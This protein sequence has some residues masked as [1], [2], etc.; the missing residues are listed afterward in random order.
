[1][2]PFPS[3]RCLAV[4][5][6]ALALIAPNALQANAAD[7]DLSGSQDKPVVFGRS[8]DIEGTPLRLEQAHVS[9]SF[10]GIGDGRLAGIRPNGLPLRGNFISSGFGMRLHPMGGGLKL[11][12]GLDFPA[13]AGTA[14]HAT[15]PGVVVFAGWSGGYG[16]CLVVAHGG[17]TTTLFGH[18][19]AIAAAPGD[20][21][22]A[23]QLIGR[24]GSTGR[25]TGPHLHYEVRRDGRPVDPRSYL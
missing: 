3:F 14:V 11:H 6:A 23:G 1:M 2:T 20:T 22:A 10:K 7:T 18:L 24:V 17:G 8:L 5:S 16:L 25:S 21:V 4:W 19:S 9:R 13:P 12:A 15:A